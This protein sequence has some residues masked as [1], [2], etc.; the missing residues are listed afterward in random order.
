MP[1]TR[2]A[3]YDRPLLAIDAGQTGIRMRYTSPDG[4]EETEVAGIDAATE[5]QQQIERVLLDAAARRGWRPATV[6]IGLTG[7]VSA[8]ARADDLLRSWRIAGVSRVLIAH[9]S[10]TGYLAALGFDPGV[11]VA[12]GT[13][14]VV[15]AA[16]PHGVARV[17]GWGHLLGDAGGGYWLGRAGL[18][19]ALRQHDGRGP[20]TALTP[21]AVEAFGSIDG[22]TSRVQERPDRV[23]AIA[24]FARYVLRRASEGDVAALSIADD[25]ARELARSAIVALER[26]GLGPGDPATVSWTGS[27]LN[28]SGVYRARLQEHLALHRGSCCLVPPRS[29]PLDGC[30]RLHAVPESHP[31]RGFIASAAISPQEGKLA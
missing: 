15:L 25:G 6:S 7:L 24:S 31:L 29:V 2:A 8:E 13:G 1:V 17:D 26:A 10:V 19:A 23:R 30:A 28:G 12:A 22:L 16:G 5:G 20:A 11:V 4:I 14:V 3:D 27:L 9:D 18:D 21:D